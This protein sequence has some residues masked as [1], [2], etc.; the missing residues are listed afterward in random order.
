MSTV[1]KGVKLGVLAVVFLVLGAGAVYLFIANVLV[2]RVEQPQIVIEK[3]PEPASLSS[4][5][6]VLG[7]TFW[8]R[9][10][11]DW[12][13]ASELK[14]AYPF[15]RLNEFNRDQYD[16]W[17]SG[18]ECPTAPG[19]DM[20]SAEMEATLT[21]NCDPSYLPEAAKWFT[22]FSL[23]NNH[24]DN[25]GIEGFAA[26][27]QELDKHGIQY[28]GHY[29]PRALDDLCDVISLPVTVMLDDDSTTKGSLPV[30]MCG[31]HGVFRVP[32]Q[33]AIAVMTKYAEYMPVLAFPHMGAEYKPEPDALKTEVYRSLIDAGADVVLGD[34]P[35]WVQTTESY[36]GRLIVYSM[37]N[38][39]FDQ[40]GYTELTRSAAIQIVLSV[41][42][43]D[44]K[45][46][47][48]WLKLG[49]SCKT[50]HDDCLDRA[51]QQGL[52]KLDVSYRF[53]VVGTDNNNKIVKPAT[54]TQLAGIL[55][56]LRW[57]QTM[58]QLQA[59]YGSL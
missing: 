6:L 2:S 49:E 4:N 43:T 10:I 40:Q 22:A 16:A 39:M 57:G 21:F 45:Q 53:G 47:E 8:G 1:Y 5:V 35:H 33:E 3:R 54:E 42:N 13:M 46:L 24:T 30:A 44:A 7:N 25:Q 23:A 32:P 17:L 52:Q 51:R 50:Y 9:Y 15:S 12:S 14:Q 19:V 48:A 11:N 26:T 34:H 56:R 36:K 41:K 55:E 38:F 31:Y 58:S 28:F 59:P 18:L 27:K 29:D 20:T 37:G